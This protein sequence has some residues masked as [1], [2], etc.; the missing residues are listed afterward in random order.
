V[1][2]DIITQPYVVHALR[3]NEDELSTGRVSS[4]INQHFH[5]NV[6]I[7]LVHE[8]IAVQLSVNSLVT[9]TSVNSQLVETSD[10]GAHSFP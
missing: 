3:C 7:D 5:A 8:D 9:A 10:R 1:N 6:A 2:F 4:S